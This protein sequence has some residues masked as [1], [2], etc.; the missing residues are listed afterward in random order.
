MDLARECGLCVGNIL[1][2]EANFG[3]ALHG[4]S[5]ETAETLPLNVSHTVCAVVIESEA[6]AK[7]FRFA[8]EDKEKQLEYFSTSSHLLELKPLTLQPLSSTENPFT[9]TDIS[10]VD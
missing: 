2:P 1:S 7:K 6:A 4:L 5:L 9:P 10:E 3:Q 8:V